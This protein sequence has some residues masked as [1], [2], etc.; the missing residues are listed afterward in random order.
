M[1]GSAQTQSGAGRCIPALGEGTLNKSIRNNF[2]YNKLGEGSGEG[3][4]RARSGLVGGWR[5]RVLAFFFE[6]CFWHPLGV[7]LWCPRGCLMGSI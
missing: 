3:R 5:I 4:N 2:Y 6:V 7:R 1:T